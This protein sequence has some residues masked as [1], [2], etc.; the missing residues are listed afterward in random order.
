MG[1]RLKFS[2]YQPGDTEEPIEVEINDG[3]LFYFKP[4]MPGTQLLSY[5]A[6]IDEA[7][8][9]KAART[10]QSLFHDT[11]ITDPAEFPRADPPVPE[12][13]SEAFFAYIGDNDHHVDLDKLQEIANDLLGEIAHGRP[14][15]SSPKSVDGSATN[16]SGSTERRSEKVATSKRSRSGN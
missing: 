8:Q 13:N 9:A 12:D 5:L 7:D 14:T 2:T 16:G 1:R 15:Q 6:D 10:I 4:S 11:V 3:N